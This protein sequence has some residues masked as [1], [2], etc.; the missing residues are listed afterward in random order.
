M[1]FL[2]RLDVKTWASLLGGAGVILISAGAFVKPDYAGSV[3][4]EIGAALFLAIPLVLVEDILENV[5][6]R[7][8]ETV[9]SLRSDLHQ[10]TREVQEARTQ[11]V[12]LGRDTREQIAA[13]RDA[14]VKAREDAREDPSEENVW[15]LLRRAHELGAT[16]PR[17]IRVKLPYSDLRMRFG[18]EPAT[19]PD[20]E[21]GSVATEVQAVDGERVAGPVVW[22]HDE[23]AAKVIPRLAAEMQALG[24]Y[25]GDDS[26]DAAAIFETLISTLDQ[27]IALRT[28]RI[29]GARLPAV[30]EVHGNVWA[31][32]IDGLAHTSHDDRRV[33]ARLLLS[34]REQAIELL[35]GADV[36]PD[37]ALAE[38]MDAAVAFFSGRDRRA[39]QERL[40]RK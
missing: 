5:S 37:G 7:Q 29:Q 25:P 24:R 31:L 33:P 21:G 15:R 9:R 8:Q 23:P 12:E 2:R 28:G 18:A 4:L 19:G 22:G 27:L 26:F 1:K 32:T 30:V 20:E 17:G 16:H 6:R 39:A 36:A 35:G 40:A 13:E 34:E 11:I 38:A 10:V 3:M 14:D